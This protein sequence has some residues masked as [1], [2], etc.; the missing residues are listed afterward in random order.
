MLEIFKHSEDGRKQKVARWIKEN[1][2]WQQTD[3]SYF[4][5]DV[6]VQFDNWIVVIIKN[7]K[8]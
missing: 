1:I 3:I 5:S 2:Q 7:N 8:E 4:T 6:L